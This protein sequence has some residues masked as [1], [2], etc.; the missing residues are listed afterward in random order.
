LEARPARGSCLSPFEP[1]FHK[2]GRRIHVFIVRS[3]HPGT[4][5]AGSRAPPSSPL[6]SPSGAVRRSLCGQRRTF[7]LATE[8]INGL[9]YD[10]SRQRRVQ[11]LSKGSLP[12]WLLCPRRR[13]RAV[14]WW[15]QQMPS[16]RCRGGRSDIFSTLQGDDLLLQH[17]SPG[18]AP[19]RWGAGFHVWDNVYRRDAEV[20]SLGGGQHLDVS[21]RRRLRRP[22]EA[23]RELRRPSRRRT[24][25]W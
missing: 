25:S 7:R 5:P 22:G 3:R 8:A 14:V 23:H 11:S 2:F 17:S 9:I 15:R 19:S 10:W 20:E 1:S 16:R 4:R 24:A 18:F 12:P 6:T 21:E 13:C